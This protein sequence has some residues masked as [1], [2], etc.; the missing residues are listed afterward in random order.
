M[1]NWNGANSSEN[2]DGLSLPDYLWGIETGNKRRPRLISGFQTT[3]EEL[4]LV[5][6]KVNSLFFPLPDY[7]WGIETRAWDFKRKLFKCFQTTYE[8]LKPSYLCLQVR[9]GLAASRLP[10]RN[11][12]FSFFVISVGS[13]SLPDYLWGIETV[14]SHTSS[15]KLLASRLPMRN[16][17]SC[18]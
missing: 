17:N 14:H 9:Q 10:M 18:V 1:R 12:N 15:E 8:E 16:W 2:Y 5:T 6:H 7:L 13:P 11:W 3:Y 4:K